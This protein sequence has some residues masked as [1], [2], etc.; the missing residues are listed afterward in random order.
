MPRWKLTLCRIILLLD[1]V[2]ACR[3]I[4]RYNSKTK[5]L[6]PPVWRFMWR[7][8]WGMHIL[9]RRGWLWPYLNTLIWEEAT[10]DEL[11]LP[12]LSDDE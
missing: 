10:I 9:S 6:E 8:L 4:Q 2:P 11:H 7:G 3:R 1:F 12:D 5:E